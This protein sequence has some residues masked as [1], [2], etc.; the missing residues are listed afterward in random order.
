VALKEKGS[1]DGSWEPGTK[2]M[3][4]KRKERT[5]AVAKTKRGDDVPWARSAPNANPK[6]IHRHSKRGAKTG[7]EETWEKAP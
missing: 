2:D 1:G 5:E 6:K 7:R 4:G 3:D